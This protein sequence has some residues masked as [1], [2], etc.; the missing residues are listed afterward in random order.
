VKKIIPHT[1]LIGAILTACALV[2]SPNLFALEN[3]VWI[4]PYGI[5]GDAVTNVMTSDFVYGAQ[6][7]VL[8]PSNIV[9]TAT[10]PFRCPDATTLN[11]V[12][13][14]VLTNACMTIHFMAGTFEVP[15]SGLT[16]LDGWKLR[17][18]GID[19]TIL[20]LIAGTPL[21]GGTA[22]VGGNNEKTTAGVEVSDL[23]IDCNMQNETG[24]SNNVYAVFVQGSQTRISRVKAINWGAANNNE[25]YVL[26]ATPAIGSPTATNCVIEDCIVTQ[27]ALTNDNTAGVTGIY[28][29]PNLRGGIIR[30]NFINN[31]QTGG[32]GPG[33]FRGIRG[34]NNVRDN[35]LYDLTG[36]QAAGIFENESGLRDVLI[37][38]NVIDNVSQGIS[39]M[40]GQPNT[41]ITIK[42]NVVRPSE[43][44][45][46]ISYDLQNSGAV[47]TNLLI[48]GNVVSPSYV[49]TNTTAL[50]LAFYDYGYVNIY[51]TVKNNIFQG[52]GPNGLD[53]LFPAGET[54]NWDQPTD[55][56]PYPL[57]LN[58]W[59]GNVNFA[60]TELNEGT[61]VNWQPGDEDNVV[62]TATA[63]GW[64]R[65]I[66]GCG[67]GSLPAMGACSGTIT[68]EADMSDTTNITDAEFSF[69]VN[70]LAASTNDLGGITLIRNATWQPQVT[71]A[72]IGADNPADGCVYLDIYVGNSSPMAGIVKDIYIGN[73]SASSRLGKN[74][75]V[76]NAAPSTRFIR[77]KSKGHFRGRLLNPPVLVPATLDLS[78][79]TDL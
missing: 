78:I 66:S 39:Y 63:D 53:I 36:P 70:G 61:D 67:S 34:N 23:T 31:I 57:Q 76:A 54:P 33:F 1:S 45:T 79:V 18:A 32:T 7:G 13:T 24:V 69:A 56:F 59:E 19:N 71:A 41:N 37:D 16:P 10:Y 44:G 73:A 46:G 15:S 8:Y 77:V 22:V 2:L 38:G 27:P 28:M 51:A 4:S 5:D 74:G 11:Y 50:G 55:R 30:N 35:Y 9:G 75:Y 21:N 40:P 20:Q 17:G 25:A 64:Y 48:D 43:G 49:A 12:M 26:V 3:D 58:T 52:S 62:F 72:R 65:L 29:T 6:H 68:V 47:A 60:G 14:S 42:N